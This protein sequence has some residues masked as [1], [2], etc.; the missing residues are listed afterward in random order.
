MVLKRISHPR[1][2]IDVLTDV[3][4]EEVIKTSVGVFA[5]NVWTDVTIGML[6]G[7]KVDVVVD[8]LSDIGVEALAD[9]DANVLVVAMIVLYF[10]MPSP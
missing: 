8:V 5:I 4:V 10:A 1:V 3:W 9:V 2:V 6:S 7:V